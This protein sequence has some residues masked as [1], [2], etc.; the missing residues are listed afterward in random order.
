MSGEFTSRKSLNECSII[1]RALIQIYRLHDNFC[2]LDF[3]RVQ[4]NVLY[5]MQLFTM[6]KAELED[7]KANTNKES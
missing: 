1:V 4:G 6:M 5:F 2:V 3:Q 7:V